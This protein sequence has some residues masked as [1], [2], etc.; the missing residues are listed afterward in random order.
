[1]S[2]TCECCDFGLD[3]TAV[4]SRVREME[5]FSPL[6]RAQLWWKIDLRNPLQLP[7]SLTYIL[8]CIDPY[9]YLP[10]GRNSE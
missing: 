5:I 9:R 1:M 6:A 10:G 7:F 3:P 2:N 8:S 4:H